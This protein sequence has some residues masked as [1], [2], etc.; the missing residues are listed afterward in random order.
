[1]NMNIGVIGH[2]RSNS[3]LVSAIRKLE[4]Q[5]QECDS[6]L[7]SRCTT[8]KWLQKRID[9]NDSVG[10]Y[11]R[12]AELRI[13]IDGLQNECIIPTVNQPQVQPIVRSAE[14]IVEAIDVKSMFCA[15]CTIKKKCSKKSIDDCKNH[16][17]DWL[18]GKEV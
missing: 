11:D 3:T 12:A 4:N 16:W 7:I 18:T 5:P 17:L 8:I 9:D 1:M 14:E 15:D 6:D 13:V 10:N 2:G